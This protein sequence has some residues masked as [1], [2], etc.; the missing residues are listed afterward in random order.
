MIRCRFA[1]SK[2]KCGGDYR[3]VKWPINTPYW[4]TGENDV[5]FIIVAYADSEEVLLQ[6]WP[7]AEHME[8]EVVD[9]IVF[10]DRFKKP[11]WY[12]QI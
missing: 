8:S 1:I 7:E 2:E 12:E 10:T 9:G 6:L 11:E 3:P 4:C 5:S